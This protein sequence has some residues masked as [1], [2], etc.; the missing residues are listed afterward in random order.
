MPRI[1]S[2]L[3]LL[4]AACRP[5][6][7]GD[8]SGGHA[9]DS[10]DRTF[11]VSGAVEDVDGSAVPD[12]YVTASDAFCTPDRTDEAGGFTIGNV[13]GG[14]K[15]LITYGDTAPGGPW[16]SVVLPLDLAGDTVMPA[17]VLAPSLTE[18][19]PVD[20]DATEEQ[21]IV[22]ADGLVLSIAPASLHL[23][24]FADPEVRVRRVPVAQSPAFVPDGATLVDLFVL[25]RILSTFDPPAAVAFPADTGLDPGTAVTFYALDYDTGWL[26]PV[27]AGAVDADGR[28]TSAEGE[29]IPELTWIAVSVEE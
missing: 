4:I 2:N 29:G 17:P 14:E 25:D 12:L 9:V 6:A 3:G 27:A 16:A 5:G 13:A 18:S 28:P 10:A 21:T 19:W 8:D 26:V 24:P 11:S 1:A 23:A 15:R 22:T 7:V 20:P